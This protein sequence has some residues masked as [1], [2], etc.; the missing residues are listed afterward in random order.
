M[1]SKRIPW[2]AYPE[3]ILE[4]DRPVAGE[5]QAPE[6]VELTDDEERL[7]WTHTENPTVVKKPRHVLRDFLELADA[8][9]EQI[10]DYARQWGVLG[11]CR[12]GLP[13]T[14]TLGARRGPTIASVILQACA[15]RHRLLKRRSLQPFLEEAGDALNTLQYDASPCVPLGFDRHHADPSDDLPR[16]AD[17]WE[18]V[19]IWRQFAKQALAILTIADNLKRDTLPDDQYWET[20]YSESG[21]TAPWWQRGLEVERLKL[22]MVLNEWLRLGAVRPSIDWHALKPEISF[23]GPRLFSMLA[24]QLAFAVSG[25][26]GIAT[27]SSCG[28]VYPRERQPKSGQRNYCPECRRRKIPERDAQR[29]RRARSRQRSTAQRR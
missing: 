28:K 12:H 18:P 8:A 10:R 6:T 27:C 9:P 2:S 20:T 17:A 14:H 4:L 26:E 19:R 22:T 13:F 21:K 15:T 23:V 25:G 16:A 11:I 3:S 24:L 7:W 29:A 1:T 5:L